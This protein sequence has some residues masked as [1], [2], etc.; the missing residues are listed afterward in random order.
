MALDM[1]DGW[2]DGWMVKCL[3]K[4]YTVLTVVQIKYNIHKLP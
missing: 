3:E 4:V 2:M 1:W